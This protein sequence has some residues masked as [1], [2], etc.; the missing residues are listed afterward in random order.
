MTLAEVFILIPLVTLR[1]RD[2]SST[3]S[4]L[5]QVFIV[6]RAKSFAACG[7]DLLP[8]TCRPSANTE[9]SRRTREKPLVPR[10]HTGTFRPIFSLLSH[11]ALH[12]FF[13]H[14]YYHV[15]Y[16]FLTP[17]DAVDRQKATVSLVCFFLFFFSLLLLMHLTK[18]NN[19]PS[20]IILTLW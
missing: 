17:D 11:F 13:H 20:Q 4:G 8:K 2:F 1:A 18:L 9:N 15:E 16:C 12:H 3:V 10:V 5:C 19:P 7:L 14:V 6:T